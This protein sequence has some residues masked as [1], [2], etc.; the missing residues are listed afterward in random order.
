M[1]KTNKILRHLKQS[2]KQ[3]NVASL[4]QLYKN[5]NQ[6]HNFFEQD[7]EKAYYYLSQC[8]E[9]LSNS[10]R[11]ITLNKLKLRD[12]RKF[13][14]IDI[15]FDE[16]LTVLI[17][18]NGAG[19]TSIVESIAKV[20][21]WV[22]ANIEKEGKNGKIVNDKDINVNS[23]HYASINADLSLNQDTLYT[24]CLAR[25]LKGMSKNK[26]SYIGELRALAN[27]YRVSNAYQEINLPLFVFYSVERSHAKP[28]HTYSLEK[29][30]D[31]YPHSRF[32]AYNG[33]LE[34]NGRFSDFLEWFVVLDNLA[35]NEIFPEKSRLLAEINTL[36]KLYNQVAEDSIQKILE[37]R[38]SEYTKLAELKN[39]KVNFS[40]QL[41]IVKQAIISLVPNI[42]DIY[43]DRSSGRADIKVKIKNQDHS[44]TINQLSQGQQ[45]VVALSAD[46]TRRLIMLNPQYNNPLEGQ[47][48]VLIDEIE[49]HLHPRWQQNILLNLQETFPRLQF[50]ITTHSPQV[51]STVDVSTIRQLNENANGQITITKPT[52]QTK[53]IISSDVLEQVMGTFATPQV[54]EAQWLE[55]FYVYIA[56]GRQEEPDAQALFKELKQHF[57]KN[58]P[59]IERCNSQIRLQKMKAKARQRMKNIHKNEKA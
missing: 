54:R 38:I 31:I 51:L 59:E 17:G 25:T 12:F 5:Y 26:S 50:I 15:D 2:A 24:A 29:I 58:H 48:I 3:G 40:D 39:D 16:K 32:D 56:E 49:L 10:D 55:D 43:V 19:K 41:N 22:V 1:K 13:S 4:F 14:T 45:I 21:S 7:K 11:K 52:F 34:G 57:G 33:A 36:K 37:E 18:D 8:I 28:P 23:D 35:N 42:L 47:G 30:N 20:L 46:L 44:V 53:G 6:G 27:L 9:E